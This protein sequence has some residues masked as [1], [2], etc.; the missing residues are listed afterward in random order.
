[1]NS[2]QVLLLEMIF[3]FFFFRCDC[4][5]FLKDRFLIYWGPSRRRPFEHGLRIRK[6]SIPRM[7]AVFF[8]L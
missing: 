2:S 5:L 7:D 6:P 4:I 3:A 1:M 8:A